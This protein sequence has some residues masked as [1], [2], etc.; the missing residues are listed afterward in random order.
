MFQD[1]CLLYT[2]LWVFDHFEMTGPS[3][4]V[5]PKRLQD[6]SCETKTQQNALVSKLYF[7]KKNPQSSVFL[8]KKKGLGGKKKKLRVKV[9]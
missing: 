7:F 5:G 2:Q 6:E 3:E 8:D 9:I 4:R 1:H